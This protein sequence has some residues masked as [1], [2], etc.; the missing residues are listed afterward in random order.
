MAAIAGD[1]CYSAAC[2]AI[3]GRAM[4]KKALSALGT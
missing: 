4:S 2:R 1:D 3:T